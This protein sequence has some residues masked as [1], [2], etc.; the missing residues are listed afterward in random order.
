[1]LIYS[2]SKEEDLKVIPKWVQW[3]ELRV[4][5]DAKLLDHLSEL[6]S[7]KVI[8]TDRWEK[9]GGKS[10]KSVEKKLHFYESLREYSNLY[11]DVEIALIESH[12]DLVL[13]YQR[14]I[15]SWHNFGALDISELASK[16][17]LACSFQPY[18]VKVA[19]HCSSLEQVRMLH[20]V[21]KEQ[22]SEILWLV[23][24]EYGTLQRLLFPYLNSRGSFI[25]N[26]GSQ[27]VEGQL[28][29]KS[30]EK[31]Q[32]LLASK[33]FKWGGIIGGK[34]VYESIG[35]DFYNRYF[36]NHK[37]PA[38]Y[39][40]ISLKENDLKDFFALLD[41][42]EELREMCYGFSLTM[43][44]KQIIPK[45]FKHGTISNLLIYGKKEAFFNT[46]YDAFMKLK[47]KMTTLGIKKILIY[48]TGSMA[49]MA[50]Q[51][52]AEY[53]V[54][55]T[56]RNK[57]KLKELRTKRKKIEII[58]QISSELYFDLLI[59]TSS[60][61]MKGESFSRETGISKFKYVID[62]PYSLAEIPLQQ[63]VG[64]KRYFSGR[65]FWSYQS[66]RQ[67]QLFKE[68]IENDKK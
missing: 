16:M 43:P 2:I 9:E 64:E 15:L 19:Q 58:D 68:R 39:L 17:Q 52:F 18:M 8:I 3:L 22:K 23:M 36:Q 4:D 40:P 5:L 34:Q 11:F 13:D 46:D 7:Y 27:T 25:A 60:L 6:G 37:M 29:L 32:H 28:T 30:V 41:N 10:K 50:L 33:P 63:E 49:E 55:L 45:F 44:F 14:M 12:P 38:C 21:I 24:G 31:Y 59:N 1:M 66:E 48:G 35:L 62:L 61:G 67:L 65:E 54:Y 56:G 47:E 26:S 51:I 42:N 53:Q 57:I 20:Q